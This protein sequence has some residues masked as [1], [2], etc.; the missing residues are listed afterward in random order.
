MSSTE[1]GTETKTRCCLEAIN[2]HK[3]KTDKCP[4]IQ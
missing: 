2:N 1:A 4:N 3:T